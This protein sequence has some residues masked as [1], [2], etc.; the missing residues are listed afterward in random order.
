MS[1]QTS[2][3]HEKEILDRVAARGEFHADHILPRQ[4]RTIKVASMAKV[5]GAHQKAVGLFRDTL[6]RLAS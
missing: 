4:Q 1:A 5:K 6:K 2:A 3:A